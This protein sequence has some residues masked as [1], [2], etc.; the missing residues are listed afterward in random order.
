MKRVL[1]LLPL[2]VLASALWG[3]NWKLDHPPPTDADEEFQS[4][5]Q[6][7]DTLEVDEF[8][9]AR[10]VKTVK[11]K[12]GQ[13]HEFIDLIQLSGRRSTML[14]GPN[15]RWKINCFRN[16]KDVDGFLL[17]PD[18]TVLIAYGARR[19]NGKPWVVRLGARSARRVKNYLLDAPALHEPSR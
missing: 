12:H 16:G 10:F 6:G 7:V 18:A 11:L 4:Q 5:I 14:P 2:L 19:K 13:L 17:T 1:F 3:V 9:G 8:E 15:Y